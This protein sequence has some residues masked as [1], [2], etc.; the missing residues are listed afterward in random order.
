MLV[1]TDW[2]QESDKD[3]VLW[4]APDENGAIGFYVLDSPYQ[5]DEYIDQIILSDE[6]LKVRKRD[7]VKLEGVGT[8]TRLL[9]GKPGDPWWKLVAATI[10]GQLLDITIA[11]GGHFG[12]K[13]VD[14]MLRSV[15][16]D[17]WGAP[18]S[19]SP[20]SSCSPAAAVGQTTPRPRRRPRRRPSTRAS[21]RH[22]RT[23]SRSSPART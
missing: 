17:A 1:P 5:A 21:R 2:E 7:K 11:T 19:S 18:P 4:G 20:R 15:E 9:L 13:Q 22:R 10:D 8:G 14:Q 6:N 23:T 16:R 12:V 3:G